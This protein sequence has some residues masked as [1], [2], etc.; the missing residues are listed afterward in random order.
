MV[1][2]FPDAVSALGKVR[3][4]VQTTQPPGETVGD[5]WIDPANGNRISTWTGTAWVL[6]ELHNDVIA[7]LSADKLIAGTIEAQILLAGAIATA[8]TG[9]RIEL[10]AA[11]LQGYSADG[12]LTTNLASDPTAAGQYISFANASG[13]T[14]AAISSDGTGVFSMLTADSLSIGGINVVNDI[15]NRSGRGIVAWGQHTA[16]IATP[17]NT[18]KGYIEIAFLAE[19]GRMYKVSVSGEID[20][21]VSLSTERFQFALRDGGAN[22]PRVSSPA[23]A[24]F[25][26]PAPGA[27]GPNSRGYFADI[28]TYT[29]GVH[30]L[31]WTFYASLGTGTMRGS[32]EPSQIWVE[33]IGAATLFDNIAIVNN[34]S[35]PPADSV[36][37][38]ARTYTATFSGSYDAAGN[39]APILGNEVRQGDQGDGRGYM[40]ALIGFNS[41]QIRA[42]LAGATLKSVQ[43]RLRNRG[44]LDRSGGT[45]IVGTHTYT[46]RPSSWA[47]S[48][49]TRDR[50][51]FTA[52]AY[53]ETRMVTLTNAIG[54]ELK[55]GATA[56]IAL[57]GPNPGNAGIFDG[58]GFSSQP[59]LVITYTN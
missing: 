17:A 30:R 57:G 1:V 21:N 28:Q 26:F 56:G 43:L 40:N 44:W 2:E 18:E 42:D 27:G 50:F 34:G 20:T 11:G 33:D 58:V 49:V 35:T 32:E 54:S 48:N 39:L 45:V 3:I 19:A 36:R 55:S 8:P 9:Q 12:A 38:Y 37:T 22:A 14:L 16:D 15:I 10:N 13:Q 52:W 59:Q 51:R 6:R 4:W 25:H 5:L 46:A 7:D 23:V 53:L 47:V 24:R 41:A 31:L 29:P